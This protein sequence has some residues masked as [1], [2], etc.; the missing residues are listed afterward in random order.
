MCSRSKVPRCALQIAA[1]YGHSIYLADTKRRHDRHGHRG[2]RPARVG[3]AGHQ[4]VSAERSVMCRP[5]ASNRQHQRLPADVGP[6][7]ASRVGSS[8]APACIRALDHQAWRCGRS[9]SPGSNAPVR[10]LSQARPGPRPPGSAAGHQAPCG[11]T[12]RCRRH[13][14]RAAACRVTVM[15]A[16]NA[17]PVSSRPGLLTGS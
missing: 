16:G 7:Q 3:R 12:V 1:P 4:R 9:K 15:A 10:R 2:R 8:R 6:W 5:R 17:S 14:R 11:W 13:C